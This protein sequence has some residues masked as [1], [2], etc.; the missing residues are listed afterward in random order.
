M[1]IIKELM[2][3]QWIWL[4]A[5]ILLIMAEFAIPGLIVIFFG[6][7]AC[8]V[9]GI[10]FFTEISVNTQLLIFIAVSVISLLALRK[11]IK[12]VFVG[13]VT[14][15]Q[16]TSENLSEYIGQKVVVKKTISIDLGGKVEFHGTSWQ[17]ESET[18]IAEGTVVEIV[19]KDNLTLKVKAL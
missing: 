5:G 13:H 12:G 7:G 3:P 15:K 9:A 11:Y 18:E 16:D 10:C 2:E 1:D 19:G 4:L 6:I 14:G 8:V 17:A